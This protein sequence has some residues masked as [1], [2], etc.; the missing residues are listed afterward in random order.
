M[1]SD[2][3]TTLLVFPVDMDAA[4]R[5]LSVAA[6]L[7]IRII[8]AS[9]VEDPPAKEALETL[10]H[11]PYISDSGFLDT[12]KT[13]LEE[14]QVTHVYTPHPGVWT[15]LNELLQEQSPDFRFTLCQ[16]SPYQSIWQDAEAGYSW[17][18]TILTDPFP[19]RLLSTDGNL[20]PALTPG[21]YAGLYKQFFQIPGQ[22]DLQKLTAFVHLARC[23]PEGDLLEI[24][25]LAGRSAFALA[26]LAERYGLG[27]LVSVDPWSNRAIE[28][29]G[30]AA[31]ILN[32]DMAGIGF[33]RI[34][35]VYISNISILANA[36]YIRDISVKAIDAYMR[37][38]AEGVLESPWL[39]SVTVTGKISLLHVDGN[40][41]YN[42]VCQDL[43]TWEPSVMPGGWVLLDDYRWAFGDG[44]K[45]AGDELLA[46]GR[47]DHSF[48]L[49]D[50][51]YLRKG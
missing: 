23:L 44:P 21:E 50:T 14:Y 9:S 46:S 19:Q 40:H 1:N 29:Q 28:D 27:S 17:A 38:A 39:G 35:Q 48:T 43:E 47:Y 16:P 5:F 8:G 18:E 12:L 45:R 30:P 37:A 20:K 42:H 4:D 25:S 24:G 26:W 7:G 2:V 3:A 11:L 15:L 31:E 13:R 51:L 33:E 41:E 6:A 36:A 34:F 49:G 10:I 22:C 32:R